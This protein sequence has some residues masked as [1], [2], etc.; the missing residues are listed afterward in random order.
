MMSFYTLNLIT[1][2]MVSTLRDLEGSLKANYFTP[3]DNLGDVFYGP[4]LRACEMGHYYRGAGYFRS[5]VLR[6]LDSDL[7]NFCK[8]GGKIH[9]LTS[10]DFNR[11][12]KDAALEGYS[13]RS[14]NSTLEEM[15]QTEDTAIPTRLLCALVAS[16]SMEIHIAVVNSGC[17]Y[18]DK[19]G[20]FEDIQGNT[21]AFVG[22]G[23]ETYP[24]LHKKGNFERFTVSCSWEPCYSQYGSEWTEMLRDAIDMH[25]FE[26]AEVLKMDEIDPDL[27]KE[28]NIELDL[29]HYSRIIEESDTG[30]KSTLFDYSK[31]HVDGPKDHQKNA[32]DR[33]IENDH[34]GGLEHATG[35]YKTATGLMA[36][37]DSLE[38]GLNCVVISTPRKIISE[39]WVELAKK[40]FSSVK[41]IPCWS[42]HQ[43]WDIAASEAINADRKTIL[44]FVNDSLWGNK[45]R[46]ILRPLG[47]SW[48]LIVDE[49]HRWESVGSRSFMDNFSPVRRMGL[50]AEFENPQNPGGMADVIDYLT[51]GKKGRMIDHLGLPDAI[52]MGF[53]RRYEYELR[54]IDLTDWDDGPTPRATA[55]NIWRAFKQEK[56]SLASVA[57][58]DLLLEGKERVLSYT[59]ETIDDADI[60]MRAIQRE[61]GE[62]SGLAYRFDK[63]TSEEGAKR[64][65]EIID[66]FNHKRTS[67][68]IAIR[69]LD[70][71]VDLPV[72]D[73]AVMA[74]STD[75]HRQW[76]QRRGRILRKREASDRTQAKII[77]FI[78]DISTFSGAVRDSLFDLGAGDLNRIDEFSQ[79]ATTIS[80]GRVSDVLTLAGWT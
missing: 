60:L 26:G 41:V 6:I 10:T 4:C 59:G 24:A 11:D 13:L 53:L 7:I 37:T 2:S 70:E 14:M 9:L 23:N 76:I 28:H 5:S 67:G 69:V 61:W 38:N 48:T 16:G 12:D 32:L 33:W 19:M 75:D 1:N 56:K 3:P 74:T 50:S 68:L 35:T 18:H 62:R 20:F 29:N 31:I 58:V 65:S 54:A 57:S 25:I 8:K 27:L 80:Q 43:G 30:E 42:D 34:R 52:E 51:S 71:G 79:S 55:N 77:D 21:V 39:N 44:V 22:S 72:A 46:S 15:L 64:R 36:A 63:V 40:S 78:L 73:A 66:D 49:A 47:D 17:L 45:G